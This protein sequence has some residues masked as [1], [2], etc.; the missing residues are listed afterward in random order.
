MTGLWLIFGNLRSGKTWFLTWLALQQFNHG[1][2]VISNYTITFAKIVL[3]AEIIIAKIDEFVKQ[4]DKIFLA[5]DDLQRIMDSRDSTTGENKQA[6]DVTINSGKDGITIAG[7]AQL[8]SM[9]DKRYREIADYYVVCRRKGKTRDPKARIHAYVAHENFMAKHGITVKKYTKRVDTDNVH[10]LYDTR[11]KI[12]TDRRLKIQMWAE[13]IKQHEDDTYQDLLSCD[14]ITE[15]RE[16]LYT[17]LGVK[18]SE[19]VAVLK[20]LGVR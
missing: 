18:R 11:Q 8:K 15:Q 16:L 14:T 4:Y 17:Y 1:A 20:A 3:P 9:V 12:Q 5:I 6:E 7:T 2:T 10:N 19:Q 13:H